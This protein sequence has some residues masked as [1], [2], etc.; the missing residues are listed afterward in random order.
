MERGHHVVIVY[1]RRPWPRNLRRLLR[2][3][4]D[5]GRRWTGRDR[6]HIDTFNGSTVVTSQSR[7]RAAIPDGDVIFA[8]H[9]LT[10]DLVADLP[11]R[12]GRK[13]YFLQS[14]EAHSFGPEEVD[15]TWRLP[16]Q[17]F[18]VAR[19]LQDLAREKFGDAS[20]VWVPNG[21]D[22]SQ[23]DAP[24]RGLHSP[25][26]I[27][28]VYSPAS[29][30]NP[31][32]AFE[33][34]ERVRRRF[35]DLRLISFGAARPTIAHRRVANMTFFHRPPQETLRDIYASADVWLCSSCVEGFGLPLLEAMACRCPVVTTRCG[36]VVDFVR[37]GQNGFLVDV[38]DA[39]GMADAVVSLLSDAQAWERASQAAYATRLELTWERSSSLLEAAIA[40]E[41][42]ECPRSNSDADATR[43]S[44]AQPDRRT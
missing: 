32:M 12:K 17:K 10:A 9:W 39:A 6:D 14:Y 31:E 34:H 33:V 35:P 41:T 15:A 7:S 5:E 30:K 18:V 23:F 43:Y 16:L 11:P 19:W 44:V 26:S 38:G 3:L 2:R 13:A 20:A 22:T 40:S 24:P 28:F 4:Y 21:V 42:T 29:V 8:T 36:G 27:G 1:P 37:D 25:R